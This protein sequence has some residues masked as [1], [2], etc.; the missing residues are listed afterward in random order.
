MLRCS[1]PAHQEKV[2]SY[3]L[4]KVLYQRLPKETEQNHENIKQ[5]STPKLECKVGNLKTKDVIKQILT[6][7][8]GKLKSY[9][10]NNVSITS[11]GLSNINIILGTELPNLVTAN[12]KVKVKLSLCF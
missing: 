5:N 10:C 3:D 1:L 7:S 2:S 8:A 12:I 6:C 4:F 9:I 11:P